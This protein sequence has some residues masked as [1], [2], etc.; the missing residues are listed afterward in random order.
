MYVSR[1]RRMETRCPSV[2]N[3]VVLIPMQSKQDQKQRK[4]ILHN[5][6]TSFVGVP[7][8][9]NGLKWGN[10]QQS[11]SLI[12]TSVCMFVSC[13]PHSP[14]LVHIF[15]HQTVSS[16]HPSSCTSSFPSALEGRGRCCQWAECWVDIHSCLPACL[17]KHF[18]L[19]SRFT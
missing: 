2:F 3:Q 10:D 11:L 9:P 14:E 15:S 17:W 5:S 18:T 12:S 1:S 8:E 13:P 4:W 6:Y 16:L 7:V 19:S